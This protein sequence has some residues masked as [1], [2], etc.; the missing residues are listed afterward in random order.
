[1]KIVGECG[2]RVKRK[3]TSLAHAATRRQVPHLLPSKLPPPWLPRQRKIAARNAR[4][5]RLI[6]NGTLKPLTKAEARAEAAK[7][8]RTQVGGQASTQVSKCPRA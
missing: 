6:R 5:R 1:M 8:K 2:K 4:L 7:A 3:R